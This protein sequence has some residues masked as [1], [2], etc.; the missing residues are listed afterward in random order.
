MRYVRKFTIIFIINL[1]VLFGLIGIFDFLS[2]TITKSKDFLFNKELSSQDSFYTISEMPIFSG[3]PWIKAYISDANDLE[4]DFSSF[5]GWRRNKYES[6][7]I[8]I[9]SLGIRHTTSHPATT[10]SSLRTAFLGGST[11]WGTCVIDSLTIPSIFNRLGAGRYDAVNLGETSY[12]AYQNHQFLQIRVI[13]GY[14]PE[15]IISYDGVNNTPG[16]LPGPFSHHRESQIDALLKGA[17][18]PKQVPSYGDYFLKP[19]INLLRKASHRMFEKDDF[20]KGTD[21]KSAVQKSTMSDEAAARFLLESWLLTKGLADQI[22]ARYYCILQPNVYVGKPRIGHLTNLAPFSY[23][24]YDHVRSQID[25]SSRY[26]GLKD[27]FIDMTAAF[28]DLDDIYFDFCH[29]MPAGNVI[30]AKRILEH[31]EKKQVQAN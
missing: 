31:I 27:C 7:T 6:V 21:H 1:I 10:A 12:N 19:T 13:D 26:A 22:N 17:D 14:R 15:V 18:S 4:M 5:T 16:M 11:I 9:D 20:Q 30:I 2:I 29:V 28:D 24:Y 25:S 8:N 3:V 23:R